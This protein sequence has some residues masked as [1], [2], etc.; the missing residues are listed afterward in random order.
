VAEANA[1]KAAAFPM[2]AAEAALRFV[3]SHPAVTSV[4]AGAKTPEQIALNCSAA[5]GKGLCA[6]VGDE[7]RKVIGGDFERRT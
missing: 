3:L 4:I 1:L 7:I 5:D 6:E 2:P